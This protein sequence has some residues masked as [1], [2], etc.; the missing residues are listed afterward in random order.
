[1]DVTLFGHLFPLSF[2][3][4]EQFKI[5]SIGD[6]LAKIYPE[7]V[8][9]Q[10]LD[11]FFE[12]KM[13][14][15]S[16]KS[17]KLDLSFEGELIKEG[18]V[19]FLFGG[20][21]PSN[22]RVNDFLKFRERI[23]LIVDFSRDGMWELN[24]ETDA[25]FFSPQACQMLGYQ[26]GELTGHLSTW[27]RLVHADDLLFAEGFLENHL[28][29]GAPYEFKC[30]MR[31]KEGRWKWILIRGHL[32]DRKKD[33]TP[34]RMIGT[35]TDINH[36][37]IIEEKLHLL[38]SR[39]IDAVGSLESG[40]AIF[41]RDEKLVVGNGKYRELF[42]LPRELLEPGVSIERVLYGIN[43]DDIWVAREIAH[44][45]NPGQVREDPFGK[46][47]LRHV[48]KRTTDG[49][50]VSLVID[51]TKR[52]EAEEELKKARQRE[53]DVGYRIQKTLLFGHLD[54][55]P[56]GFDVYAIS[57]PSQGIDGDFYDFYVMG[58]DG[59]DLVIGDVMGKG[60]PAALMGAATKSAFSRAL[61][62][63]VGFTPSPEHIVTWVHS[64]VSSEMINLETFMTICYGRFDWLNKKL[65]FVD[66]GHT[67]TLHYKAKEQAV[68]EISGDNV[69]LGFLKD[70]IYRENE[71]FFACEDLFIFYSDG[72]TES[73]A[74]DGEFFGTERLKELIK[75][76][77]LLKAQEIGEKLLEELKRFTSNGKLQDDLT[78]IIVKVETEGPA[79]LEEKQMAVEGSFSD[80]V[81]VRTFVREFCK[82]LEEH[83]WG[84][85][86]TMHLEL[87]V[88]EALTNIIEHALSGQE[89][90]T[91]VIKIERFEDHLLLHLDYPGSPFKP[92]KPI[93]PKSEKMAEGGLG[94]Y[95]ME[96]LTEGVEYKEMPKGQQRITLRKIL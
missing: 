50:L 48:E 1:M 24:L 9:G 90:T 19:Y 15:F 11:L 65:T 67:S 92:D 4:N 80:L 49:G 70:E 20:M 36:E 95:L 64:E 83:E 33:G 59:F 78:M 82:N 58:R 42:S 5:H 55:K 44:F 66:A 13:D 41:D 25:Y 94:L 60:I 87:A 73:R 34:L 61:T 86:K 2:S 76:L 52:K 29:K 79:P 30:R 14:P 63:K 38:H 8:V 45:R 56:I 47:W 69:P 85:T 17:Q 18:D 57:M 16:I 91:I 88:D 37:K 96:R 31:T 93:R 54:V 39:L 84:E 81:S 74:V 68:V 43:P 75:S 89:D 40:F 72:V 12:V 32:V 7:I 51:I 28:Q 3:F 26:A 62:S 10:P 46:K 6:F 27:E 21:W 35:Y 53:I 77:S 23:D 22:K 71:V